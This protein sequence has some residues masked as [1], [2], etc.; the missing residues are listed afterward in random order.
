MWSCLEK[1][2]VGQTL[3]EW[4]EAA[5]AAG[6]LELAQEHTQVW[7]GFLELL[8]E[9]VVGL[10]DTVLTTV[11]YAE[12]LASGLEGYGWAWCLPVWTRCWWDL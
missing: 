12:I 2:Q 1:L 11:E 10:G 8:D 6:D 5:T 7:T 9:L 4:A 3:T